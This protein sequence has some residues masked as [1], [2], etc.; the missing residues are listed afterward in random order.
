MVRMMMMEV[1]EFDGK[2]KFDPWKKNPNEIFLSLSKE[3]SFDCMQKFI[4]S[5]R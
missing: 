1:S 5:E 4:R 2:M 3:I